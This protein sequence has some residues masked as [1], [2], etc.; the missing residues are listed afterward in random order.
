MRTLTLTTPLT[1]GSDVDRAQRILSVRGYFVG[2][3]DGVFGEITGRACTDAKYA[4][5]Y[6]AKNIKPSYGSDLEAFLTGKKPTPA[7]RIR[8]NQRKK[9]TSI[10]EAA[11]KVAREYVGVKENPAGSNRVVFSEW[12]GV[13]GPWCAMF[14]TYCMVKAGS[15][16]FE[17]ARRYAYCPYILSDAKQN[18]GMSVVSADDAESGDVVLY[19]WRQN[20]VADH[21]GLVVTPPNGGV[22]FVAIEGNTAIGA[23]SDGGEVMVRQRQVRDVIAF[24]RC[25]K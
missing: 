1:R 6:A 23:D 4:L 10:G 11:L 16:T 22:S 20:G 19:S 24:V 17:R 7:M 2:K 15:K 12:Y 21:V 9:K 25:V 18:R 5:G 14:V 3:V 13:T 8:A